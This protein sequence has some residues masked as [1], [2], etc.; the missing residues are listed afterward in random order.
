MPPPADDARRLRDFARALSERFCLEDAKAIERAVARERGVQVRVA[1]DPAAVQHAMSCAWSREA[2]QPAHFTFPRFQPGHLLET[3]IYRW[4]ALLELFLSRELSTEVRGRVVINFNDA[5]I[6]P[7]LAF[8]GNRPEYRLI[9]DPDFFT[10]RGYAQ[11]RD[12]FAR[13][14][15]AWRDRSPAVFWRGSS[16]GRKEHTALEMPRARLCQVAR[17]ASAAEF[18]VGLSEVVDVSATEAAQLR[19]AGLVKDR[20]SWKRLAQFRYHIDIDGN[21]NSFA[22]LFRKLLSGGVVFKVAS[23]D[24]YAQWYYHRLKPWE[25]FVPV[26]SDLG[27]LLEAIA[28]CREQ[29]KLAQ[30]IAQNG[31]ALALALRFETEFAGAVATVRE[32]FAASRPTVKRWLRTARAS[33]RDWAHLSAGCATFPAAT[34]QCP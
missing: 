34:S 18:D 17:D 14:P 4:L 32:A 12:H 6:E 8:S 19:S 15:V 33:A 26:R 22:G 7:G 21:A 24:C 23:P 16:L 30:Q 27:D 31:R 2:G 29:D 20:V 25:N 1:F 11:A 10:T 28:R 13:A 9:P 3:V 5:G